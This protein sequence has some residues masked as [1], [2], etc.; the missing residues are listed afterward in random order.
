V[1][2]ALA[3]AITAAKLSGIYTTRETTRYYP[4]ASLGGHVLGFLGGNEDGSVAGK[5]GIEGFFEKELAGTR[6]YL[7]AERDIAGRLITIADRL[8]EKAVDGADFVLTIDRT[9]QY[10]ACAKLKEAVARHQASGG[11]V[12]IL[13][14]KTGRILAM[15]G[16]PDFDPGNYGAAPSMF[17]YNNPA[18]FDDYEPGSIFKPLTLAAALD[19]EA[20]TPTALYD[21]TGAIEIDDF[22]IKNSN[23]RAFGWQSM[24]QV[25]EKSLNTGAI[26]AMRSIGPAVFA[27]YVRRFGFGELT[28][29]ELETEVAGDVSSLESGQEIYAATASFGQGITATVLQ[30]AAAFGVI[31]NDGILKQ[32]HVV[33]EIRWPDGSV[34]KIEPSDVR[35][36]ISSKAA[37][38]MG[39]M[40]ISVIENNRK[41][42]AGVPG[43]YLAGKTGTAQVAKKGGGGYEEGETIASYA[44]FGPVEDPRFVVVVRLDSPREE[45]ADVTAAPLFRSLAAF[46]LDYFEIPPTRK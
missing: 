34:Q 18:I 32:V 40:M 42:Y 6:G 3:A 38:L 11:S 10:T 4:E 15:C 26:F 14:P 37:R 12:V 17:A 35:R 43:Y 2:E 22:T 9:V 24:T 20:I 33:E 29:V 25:L 46:L 36:V 31:A 28:G 23:E 13:E 27:D 41:N 7:R 39:A 8:Q 45:W 21:D 30:M 44:G 5:Y 19:Q 16:E 1:S